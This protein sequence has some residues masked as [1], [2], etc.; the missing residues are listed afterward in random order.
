LASYSTFCSRAPLALVG[1]LE[2][3]LAVEEELAGR[4]I[5]THADVH[6]RL[7]TGL[8]NGLQDRLDGLLVGTSNW[9]EAAF[10]APA[11]E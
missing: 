7:V 5:E 1:F 6:A 8:G 2:N 11:V 10:V 3:V 9:R 4:R